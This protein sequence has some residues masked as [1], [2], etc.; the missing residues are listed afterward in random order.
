VE[1]SAW[2]TAISALLVFG[3]VGCGGAASTARKTVSVGVRAP[4]QNLVLAHRTPEGPRIEA[5]GHIQSAGGC[6]QV[7]GGRVKT[8]YLWPDAGHCIRITPND[9]LLFVNFTDTGPEHR[10]ASEVVITLGG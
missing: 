5:G 4:V 3:A 9:R 10:E 6:S 7:R 1:K 2:A 8:I